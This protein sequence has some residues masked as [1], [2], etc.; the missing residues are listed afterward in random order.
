MPK[1]LQNLTERKRKALEELQQRSARL[2]E[3]NRRLAEAIQLTDRSTAERA[4]SLL[5]CYQKLQVRLWV[6]QQNFPILIST[7]AG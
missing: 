3:T 6:H 2:V 1:L 5:Q 4:S 7:G